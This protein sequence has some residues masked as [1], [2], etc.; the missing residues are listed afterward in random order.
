[1]Q[2]LWVAL[3]LSCFFLV[4]ESWCGVLILK[5]LFKGCMLFLGIIY[6]P[7]LYLSLSRLHAFIV[8]H[9][10]CRGEN[11]LSPC[12]RSCKGISGRFYEPWTVDLDLTPAPQMGTKD[13]YPA[14]DLSGKF[15]TLAGL[16]HAT[17]TLLDPTIM[18]FGSYSVLGNVF[19][20]PASWYRY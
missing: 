11:S 5:D 14:G 2:R 16:R 12:T 15:G 6:I 9:P 17:T 13:L 4:L 7:I 18:L 8:H 3:A 19:L 1:M 10:Q 20:N